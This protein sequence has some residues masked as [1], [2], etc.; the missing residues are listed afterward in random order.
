VHRAIVLSVLIAC[1]NQHEQAPPAPPLVSIDA[2]AP[3]ISID[4]AP[5]AWTSVT[6]GIFTAS[7]PGAPDR[8]PQ[9]GLMYRQ[10]N[11]SY[12]LRVEALPAHW[13][14]MPPDKVAVAYSKAARKNGTVVAEQPVDHG[15]APGLELQI[16][17]QGVR[18]YLS[19]LP[20]GRWIGQLTAIYPPGSLD[21]A[22]AAQ[23]LASFHAMPGAPVTGAWEC[24][25]LLASLCDRCGAS[26]PACA[27]KIAG[28]SR[29]ACAMESVLTQGG[30]DECK[31]IAKHGK[32]DLT[33]MKHVKFDAS[34]V[35]IE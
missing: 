30:L 13:I 2:A 19:F 33:G 27:Q 7:M 14:A 8:D 9:R 26:S 32:L 11:V 17:A 3:P 24:D 29:D 21:E 15:G 16:E 1:G 23:F 4:A 25:A 35:Q 5:P 10:G 6:E 31:A 28:A 22:A 20:A 12:T 18:V 34:T